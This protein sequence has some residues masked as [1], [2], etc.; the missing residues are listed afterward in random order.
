MTGLHYSW[1]NA[2][3]LTICPGLS[4]GTDDPGDPRGF[5]LI[6]GQL[7]RL[8]TRIDLSKAAAQ[9]FNTIRQQNRL[10]MENGTARHTL[11]QLQ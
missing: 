10:M 9:D 11:I 2:V 4:R 1:G 6:E 5:S 7:R 3:N 8:D